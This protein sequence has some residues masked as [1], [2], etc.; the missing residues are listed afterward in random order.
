MNVTVYD[1]TLYTLIPFVVMIA[2]GILASLYV[3]T[4]KVSSIAQHFVAGIV[5]AAVAI[6]LIPEISHKSPVTVSIG[7]AIGAFFM[8]CLQGFTSYMEKDEKEGG[9]ISYGMLFAVGVDLFVDGIL[10]GV[11]FLAGKD[12]G[13][14][15]AISLSLC[16]LF[17]AI[18]TAT[19]LAK[20][21]L[22]FF[23]SS[24]LDCAA[25]THA[26]HR[27]FCGRI[28]P[29]LLPCFHTH[30]NHCFFWRR[31]NCWSKRTK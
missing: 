13:I 24:F 10:I 16:A 5:F 30:R 22:R 31:K 21:G 6:E 25:W 8:L 15:I 11:S 2:G 12:T 23:F 17:L 18:T 27:G 26:S 4:P 7:F 9:P 29:S 14:L 19:A 1:V 3:P 20:K 28:R